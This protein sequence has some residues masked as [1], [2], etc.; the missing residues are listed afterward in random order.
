MSV[1]PASVSDEPL[2]PAGR[3]FLSPEF[4]TIIHCIIRGKDPINIDAV[5][6]T[7]ESSLMLQHP[8]FCSLLMRDRN[9]NQY[10]KRTEVDIDRHVI[11]INGRIETEDDSGAGEEDDDEEAVN[12]Y[13]ADY[14]SA[15]RSAR[16][17]RC[18]KFTS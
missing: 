14:Q 8:R 5:K 17:N 1:S 9:G 16:I 10:W 12:Q 11:V 7:I 6:P 2:T 15:P 3:L 18:G 13:V 4:D